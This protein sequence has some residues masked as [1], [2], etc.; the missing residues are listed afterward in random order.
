MSYPRTGSLERCNVSVQGDGD[1]DSLEQCQRPTTEST[2]AHW[3]CFRGLDVDRSKMYS[4]AKRVSLHAELDLDEETHHRVHPSYGGTVVILAVRSRR[5]IL[6]NGATHHGSLLS[7]PDTSRAGWSA[8]RSHDPISVA[9]AFSLFPRS[10]ATC[11]QNEYHHIT[12]AAT[13]LASLILS[14]SHFESSLRWLARRLQR[15][16]NTGS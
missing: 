10:K 12:N 6:P 11:N 7:D 4:T 8:W 15:S 3:G 1:L 9:E 16:T 14:S 5:P 2:K 13:P